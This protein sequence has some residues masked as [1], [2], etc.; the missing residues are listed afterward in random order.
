MA[1]FTIPD[2]TVRQSLQNGS[3]SDLYILTGSSTL[4][5][6]GAGIAFT[7]NDPGASDVLYLTGISAQPGG[8][9][10]DIGVLGAS[11]ATVVMGGI[12]PTLY[13]GS[14]TADIFWG[15]GP[16]TLVTGSGNL[17][18]VGDAS[19]AGVTFGGGVSSVVRDGTGMVVTTGLGAV[20]KFWAAGPVSA[21][22][23]HPRPFA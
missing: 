11:H 17:N 22:C 10:S 6:A 8:Y 3:P 7:S 19:M 15:T 12:K 9:S 5:M 23:P 4:V 16:A 13:G 2:G 20:D 21:A 14:G 1:T 18:V